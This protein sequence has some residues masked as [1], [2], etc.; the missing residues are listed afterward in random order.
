MDK[1]YIRNFSIVAHIDHGKSTLADRFLEA[2][3]AIDKRDIQAQV[4]DSM[5]LERERGITI[6]SHPVRMTYKASDGKVYE[7]NL[8]DT[9][10]HVDF[11][12]EVSRSLAACEGALLLVD[13]A[14][15][16]QAQTVA[17]AKL[18]MKQ[19]LV[20]IPVINKIDLPSANIDLCYQQLEEVLA[21]PREEVILTSAKDG[22]GVIEIL[23]TVVKR[24]P[25]PMT[26]S[27]I[28][29]TNALIFDSQYNAYR[30]VVNY[31][32]VEKGFL[33]RG[34]KIRLFSNDLESD[35]KEVGYFKPG[36]MVPL[37]ELTEGSVGYVIP[38]IKSPAD[39][40]IGDTI[41]RIDDL[42]LRQ[43]PGF[44]E[45][46]PLVFSG[47]YPIDTADYEQLKF[48]M[49]KLQLNDSAFIYQA[50]SC[51]ALGFGFRCGFLGLLHMEIIQERLRREYDM[52]IIAT[53]PSVVYRVFPKS[54]DM[55]LI[56]NPIHLPDPTLIE[57]IEEPLI[58]A[59]IMIPN[60][61]IGEVM[62]LVMHKRGECQCTESVDGN[63]VIITAILPLHEILIDFHDKLKSC[64][65]GYGS[66]DYEESGYR[67]DD[68]VKLDILVH[69]EPVDAFS[70][71][72]HRS[73]AEYRGR[74]IAEKL[75]DV[76]PPQMFQVPI[77]AAIGGKV[78]ARE[79]VRQLRK[80]VLAKCYGGDI[81]RKRKL[82]EK[83][84]EGKKKMKQV[85]KVNIPQEAFVEIL[86][87]DTN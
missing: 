22:T 18:A 63:H 33:K 57:R 29:G 52:D 40:K 47:I 60:I 86:K 27:D 51:V 77:Q 2:T 45:I 21:I 73:F 34:H 12:Y 75:K 42:S 13:A 26:S 83:Q 87:S 41:T 71:I 80:N 49:A 14:Q 70:S 65:K 81:T 32:K 79:T 8:I 85:G 46:K 16:I 76:I 64:T 5:D 35:I 28:K 44:K 9:P 43:L 31:V 66:M 6:K 50:E 72:V 25:P 68:M 20:I 62:N 23:E 53:Y 36:G 7:F 37:E 24:V 1:N 59:S 17:N 69:G 4:L 82:L 67:A 56:D 3:N 11:T 48:S 30:G 61:Y 58:K 78:I 54:G 10:G 84:K 55:M 19:K 39:T 74:Q 15:G 38:N